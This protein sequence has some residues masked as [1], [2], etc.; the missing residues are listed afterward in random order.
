MIKS[1]LFPFVVA[2]TS[3][4]MSPSSPKTPLIRRRIIV[5]LDKNIIACLDLFLHYLVAEKRLAANTVA[6]YQSDLNHL[7]I[8]LHKKHV[9]ITAINPNHLRAYLK[10]LHREKR[11][12][13][14]M[15]RK[16]SCFRSFF[17]FLHTEKIIQS[18]PTDYLDGPKI[19]R[20]LPKALS[21][22]EVN[23]LLAGSE[24]NPLGLR[25]HAMLHLLYATGMRVSELI[26]LEITSVNQTG[27]Y[28]RVLGKGD[29]ERL[30]PFSQTAKEILQT[31]LKE[32]RPLLLKKKMSRHLF[33]SNR[34]TG[35][36]RARFW[37]IISQ[38]AVN[39]GITKKI[40]PHMIR[41]SFATHLLAGDADLRAVQMMLGHADIATTEI[42]THV[43]SDRLKAIHQKFHPRG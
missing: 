12:S 33:L 1:S 36:T 3:T 26:T 30:I 8:F 17:T 24:K 10:K 20:T 31:Y 15:N 35:M 40:S 42:Y 28:V 19:G 38:I 27:G 29:K 9:D 7:F 2:G 21:I 18:I 25:N 13:R 11:S 32:S 23:R 16:L 5:D 43:D 22:N 34:G 6:S 4:Y 39:N 41:H 37:Q 14:T